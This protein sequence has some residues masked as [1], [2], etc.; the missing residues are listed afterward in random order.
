MRYQPP[1]NWAVEVDREISGVQGQWCIP[2]VMNRW[3]RWLPRRPVGRAGARRAGLTALGLLAVTAVLAVLLA[4]RYHLTGATVV[5]SILGAVPALA[6]LYLAWAA[7][8]GAIT[9][10]EPGAVREPAHGRLVRRW[11]PVELGVH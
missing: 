9:P 11:D 1:E 7:L 10:P 8:P 2:A 4:V 3:R 6:A 5:T